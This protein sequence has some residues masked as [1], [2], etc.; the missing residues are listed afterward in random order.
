GLIAA[1]L[2]RLT[3]VGTS[4]DDRLAA[5]RDTLKHISGDSAPALER[6]LANEKDPEVRQALT[7][8]LS[9]ARLTAGTSEQRMAAISVLSQSTDPGMRSLLGQF[10][11]SGAL[12]P[13]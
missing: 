9:A 5:A 7:V 11:S 3:L 4:R 2:S 13:A 6:A 8:A 1:A 10:A 12:Y